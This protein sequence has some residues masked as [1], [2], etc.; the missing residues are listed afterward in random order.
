MLARR[1]LLQSTRGFATKAATGQWLAS[2][3]MG[4]ADP[5]LGLTER[6]NK[7]T[8]PRK[9][10]LGVGAYRDDDSKP[11]VLP[12]VQEAEKRILAA[13]KNKEYAG[14]AGMKDFVDLSLQFAYGDDCEALKAGRI[15]GVQTISGTGGVRLAG[16]F[17]AKFLGE[18]TPV[19]LPNPTWGNHI[20]IMKNAGMEVRRYTYY[21]PASR[22]LDFSGLL[23][24]LEG[25]P[26]G[27]VFLLH[28]CAHNPTG[29]DPTV[30]QWKKIAD[31]M[32]AKKHVPFFDC[33]YQGFA[34]GDAT[35]DAAAIRHFVKEG[36]NIILSQSYA[37]NFGL[38]GE[39]VG[40]L[41]VVTASKEEAERVQSQLK[42]IIRPMYSNPPIHGSLIV[43]TILSDAQ[44]KKQWYSEC[45]GMADR[46][47]SMRTALRSAIEKIEKANGVKSDWRHITD[48]IGMFCYTGLTEPQVTRMIEEHHIYL[49]KDGRVSMAGITSK[50]VEYVAQSI[51]EVVQSA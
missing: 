3:P 50:N 41:S 12:S 13:G 18:G 17:F 10:S 7:D 15:T 23:N 34:S 51:A 44:L 9:I 35:R 27:S 43:S 6:F 16:E 5:I 26:D 45:K 46:I 32:K 19:Y 28:A 4:P 47:I 37:K 2:V 22:G 8:D 30:E 24:D 49:T 1:F 31:V 33:A 39:R 25:A 40:A 48:Q 11:Y 29:V 21:E 20:P 38:Y 14:I 36:H 42:I